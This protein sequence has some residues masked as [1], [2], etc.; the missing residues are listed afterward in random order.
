MRDASSLL[1]EA[2]AITSG[3]VQSTNDYVLNSSANSPVAGARDIG[4]G[5]QLYVDF[6]VVT[7]FDALATTL[8]V[9]LCVSPNS[10]MADANA[11]Q[12]CSKRIIGAKLVAGARWHLP[13]PP[14]SMADALDGALASI[15]PGVANR[16]ALL[17]TVTGTAF[18]AGAV[19]A[20]ITPHLSP[21]GAFNYTGA[22]IPPKT[23]PGRY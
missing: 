16:F 13:I 18:T 20:S 17:Y 9:I 8:D 22:R 3:T 4:V 6:E 15:F 23:Y 19:T 21:T 7:T 2:Q 11:L 10:N 1:S 14:I 12:L 5:T